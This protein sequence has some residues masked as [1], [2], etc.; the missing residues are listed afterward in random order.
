MTTR[1]GK[2]LPN[3]GGKMKLSKEKRK[4]LKIFLAKSRKARLSK[5]YK[6]AVALQK[7]IDKIILQKKRFPNKDEYKSFFNGRR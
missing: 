4:E 5:S 1:Q 7:Y 2:A 3:T 6:Q